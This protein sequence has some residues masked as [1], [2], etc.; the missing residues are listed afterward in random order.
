L[1]AAIEREEKKLVYYPEREQARPKVKVENYDI[2]PS[3]F[4]CFGNYLTLQILVSS[5]SESD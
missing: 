4:C 1:K 3:F 2:A 5:S